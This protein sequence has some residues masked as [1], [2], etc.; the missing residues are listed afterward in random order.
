VTA[1]RV[2]LGR[3]AQLPAGAS[4]ASDVEV[5][6]GPVILWQFRAPLPES[7]ES[8][9]ALVSG[10]EPDASAVGIGPAVA[11]LVVMPF[12]S[13][14]QR[15][16]VRALGPQAVVAAHEGVAAWR[17]VGCGSGPVVPGAPA[18]TLQLSGREAGR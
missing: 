1:D 16:T 17:G 14:A 6:S 12:L 9:C 3:R 10:D 2:R 13:W 18:Q 11:S 8:L 4:P 5:S 7:R 15:R